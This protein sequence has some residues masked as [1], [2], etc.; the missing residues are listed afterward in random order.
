M[1]IINQIPNLRDTITTFKDNPRYNKFRKNFENSTGKTFLV[2]DTYQEQMASVRADGTLVPT[3]FIVEEPYRNDGKIQKQLNLPISTNPHYNT[4]NENIKNTPRKDTTT[5]TKYQKELQNL[6]EQNRPKPSNL[7][8][9]TQEEHLKQISR[10]LTDDI[11]KGITQEQKPQQN[12]NNQEH[13][14]AIQQENLLNSVQVY[15]N[16]QQREKELENIRGIIRER[17]ENFKNKNDVKNLLQ[18]MTKKVEHQERRRITKEIGQ[19]LPLLNQPR[20][21]AIARAL[22]QDNLPKD[23]NKI[24]TEMVNVSKKT[25]NNR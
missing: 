9:I 23:L 17:K 6:E 25:R 12:F 8:F 18:E 21:K 13:Q 11:I 16:K 14:L 5:L 1:T 10:K 19:D 24:I 22:Y 15:H 7:S 3:G 2:S 20:R 4:Q